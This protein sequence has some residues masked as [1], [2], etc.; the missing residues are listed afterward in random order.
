MGQRW[1]GARGRASGPLAVLAAVRTRRA[2][3]L[4]RPYQP[5]RPTAV[6]AR[7][8]GRACRSRG[9]SRRRRT[10]DRALRGASSRLGGTSLAGVR[11]AG[12]R[13]MPRCGRRRSSSRH[14]AEAGPSTTNTGADAAFPSQTPGELR[15]RVTDPADRLQVS[16]AMLSWL[17]ERASEH[18]PPL[19]ATLSFETRHRL[20]PACSCAGSAHAGA[21]ARPPGRSA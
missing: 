7:L 13:T 18:L 6:D 19:L 21:A 14:W 17:G 5:P 11:A 15:V 16:A 2:A 9:A 1:A 10:G 12:A 4:G 8:S 3:G 20:P